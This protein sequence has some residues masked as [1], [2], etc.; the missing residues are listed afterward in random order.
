MVLVDLL[1]VRKSQEYARL[2]RNDTVMQITADYNFHGHLG[3][4]DFYTLIGYNY[5]HLI[6]TL[7]CGYNRQLC[8]WWRDHGY[9][10]VFQY[11][12]KCR[13]ETVV[14]HGNCNTRI[15]KD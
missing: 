13:H 1:A 9:N 15:P 10:D 14:L 4:Q 11:Y 12:F 8:T 5:P 3:D 2:L 6:Q 7:H